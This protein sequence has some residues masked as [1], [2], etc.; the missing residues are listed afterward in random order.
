MNNLQQLKRNKKKAHKSFLSHGVFDLTRGC[1]RLSIMCN[2]SRNI[3]ILCFPVQHH[4]VSAGYLS[5]KISWKLSSKIYLAASPSQFLSPAALTFLVE[6][7]PIKLTCHAVKIVKGICWKIS[8]PFYVF[9]YRQFSN[10]RRTQSPN[11]NGSR[12]VLRLSLPNPLKP[13]VKL[14]MKM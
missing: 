5:G 14:R 13:G 6:S 1:W 11:K 12:L 2:C 4:A 7:I 8:R 9:E 3:Q 10:I